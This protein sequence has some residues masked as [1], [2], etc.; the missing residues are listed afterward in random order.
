MDNENKYLIARPSFLCGDGDNT[1][2][3]DYNDFPNTVRWEHDGEIVHNWNHVDSWVKGLID[4]IENESEGIWEQK[5]YD[6]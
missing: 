2:R 1:N 5:Y 3:F 6:E 4:E